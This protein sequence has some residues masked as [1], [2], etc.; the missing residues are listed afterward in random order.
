MVTFEKDLAQDWGC[1]HLGSPSF[2][3]LRWQLGCPIFLYLL[4]NG[5]HSVIGQGAEAA[6]GDLCAVPL[7]S[8]AAHPA[9]LTNTHFLFPVWFLSRGHTQ[10]DGQPSRML[11]RAGR[12]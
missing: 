9:F 3:F 10:R 6:D 11:P 2:M 12:S 8:P 4:G 1:G 5:G 7:L